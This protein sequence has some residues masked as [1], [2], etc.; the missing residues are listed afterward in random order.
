VRLWRE[1]RSCL[2]MCVDRLVA[3]SGCGGG[4]GGGGGGGVLGFWRF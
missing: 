1:V 2:R 4:G 3:I